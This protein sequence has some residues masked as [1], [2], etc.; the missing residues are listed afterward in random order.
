MVH[1]TMPYTLLYY[2][3]NTY[4]VLY[5]SY[6]ECNVVRSGSQASSSIVSICFSLAKD[7]GIIVFYWNKGGNNI[8]NIEATFFS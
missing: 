8:R 6:G 3:Y 4:V 5:N 1:Y 7:Y 2:I